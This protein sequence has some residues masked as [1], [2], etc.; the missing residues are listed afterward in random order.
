ML[1]QESSWNMGSSDGDLSQ[2]PLQSP[3][4][5]NFFFPGFQFPG[6]LA[7]AGLT[8]PEFQLTSDTSI[9]LQMNFFS[10]AFLS[11]ANTNGITSFRNNGSVVMDL[12]PWLTPGFT[13][14]AGVP[15]LVDALNTLLLAGQLSS[16]AKDAIVSYVANVQNFPYGAAPT[17][18]QMLNR[19]R[20]VVHMILLSP[21]FN[22]QK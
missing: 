3:T 10:S 11:T 7:A 1:I 21:D 6:P 17:E 18:S 15:S 12:G 9:G 20:A 2:T 14:D 19:V 22:I 5:F 16:D 8:T 4:V 13:S